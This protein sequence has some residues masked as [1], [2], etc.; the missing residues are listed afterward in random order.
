MK[1]I[2]ELWINDETNEIILTLCKQ[3]QQLR[4]LAL[5]NFK[6]TTG[7]RDISQHIYCS[8]VFTFESNKGF[9]T[10]FCVFCVTL[11]CEKKREATS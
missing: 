2:Y 11:E 7:S 4:F 10:S 5:K 3:F 9:G 8:S 6:A 1:D